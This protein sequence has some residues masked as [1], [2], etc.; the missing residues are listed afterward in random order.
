MWALDRCFDGR[1]PLPEALRTV[2]EHISEQRGGLDALQS[3]P[4]G[5]MAAFRIYEL[6]AFVNRVRTLEVG[7]L[8]A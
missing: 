3:P 2:M 6:A 1:T 4:A 5:Q 8:Q 7:T